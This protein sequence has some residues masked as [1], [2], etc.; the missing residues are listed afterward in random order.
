MRAIGVREWGGRDRMELLDVANPKV[1][2]DSVLIRVGAAGLNPVDHK[3]RAG[4]LAGA[5]PYRFPVVLGWDVAGVV[6]Q[7]GPAVTGFSPGDAVYAYCRKQWLE[8]GTYAELVSAPESFVALRP[9]SMDVTEAGALPLA[10]LTAYQCLVDAIGL[11]SRETV[12]VHAG[13]GG[14]GSFAVQIAAS[15]GARVIATASAR[16]HDLL[17][18]LGAEVTIDYAA[19]DPFA[20]V[21]AEAPDGVDAVVDPL[22]GDVQQQSLDLLRDGGRLASIAEPPEL[23]EDQAQ[24]GLIGRY[25]FVRQ[26]GD[27][28]AELTR[29]AEAGRLRTV[30]EEV[31]PLERAAEAHERLEGGHVR[32]KLALSID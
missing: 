19:D 15:L 7:V 2:P 20:G 26:R 24:R 8:E 29:L 3:V 28:L 12:L 9:R 4:N 1:G 18:E 14:V 10:G 22:G 21:R 5:F 31:W 23:S 25:V 30:L 32:G 13:S 11:R 6:E 27:Q 17:R 16:N